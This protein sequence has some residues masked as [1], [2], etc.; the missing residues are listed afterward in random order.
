MEKSNRCDGVKWDYPYSYNISPEFDV[1][2]FWKVVNKVDSI[3]LDNAKQEF[4]E[5]FLDG[6]LFKIYCL[7]G[8]TIR[9]N[10][11]WD[12]GAVFIDSE[13]NLDAVFGDKKHEKR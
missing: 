4:I 13:I 10:C 12:I 6:S 11:D 3:L 2:S 8:R 7:D 1:D 5:D 9:V